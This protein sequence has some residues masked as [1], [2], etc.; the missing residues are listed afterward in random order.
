[1]K[2]VTL[3]GAGK[4]ATH[5]GTALEDNGIIIQEVFSRDIKKARSLARR[6]YDA[7]PTD[8]LNFKSSYSEVFIIAVSDNAI[9]D[10]A[11]QIVLPNHNAI[12]AH[13]SGATPLESLAGSSLYTGIFYPLQ[14][15]SFDKTVDFSQIP[16][17]IDATTKGALDRLAE[18]AHRLTPKV[19]HLTNE[20]RK[21][22]HI[23]AVFACNFTNYLME[24]SSQM[25]DEAGMA[26]QDLKHLVDETIEK[27]FTLEA[28]IDGQTGPAIRK[29]IKTI[30]RHQE[31]LT[32]THPNFLPIYQMMTDAIQG[33]VGQYK[34]AH[35][36]EIDRLEKERLLIEEQ[37][38][39]ERAASGLSQEDE[40]YIA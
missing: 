9:S 16:V 11:E 19:F 7:R 27:A 25:A 18:L 14:T 20:E 32:T 29:D 1:M 15:F 24:V 26:F 30:K 13:T 4:V 10:V 35:E 6:F 17:C 5:L 33:K 23:S 36:V 8:S 37:I 40:D 38:E 21:K 34:T 2:R 39:K 22:L 12:L 3:I 28:P 31:S